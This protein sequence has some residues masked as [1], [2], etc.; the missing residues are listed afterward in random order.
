MDL[1]NNDQ[2]RDVQPYGHIFNNLVDETD[3]YEYCNYFSFKHYLTA[4]RLYVKVESSDLSL[5][6]WK[7]INNVTFLNQPQTVTIALPTEQ[8]R[9][10]NNSNPLVAGTTPTLPVE[11]VDPPVRGSLG[12]GRPC[13]H[14]HRPYADGG[15]RCGA[16]GICRD[17]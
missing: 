1:K 9:G 16:S 7:T 2:D 12:L 3:G 6:S 15:K 13:E 14:A 5:V 8:N 4:V 17:S 11:G 10:E